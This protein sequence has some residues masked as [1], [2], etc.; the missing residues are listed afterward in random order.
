MPH[1]DLCGRLTPCK[2]S[3]LVGVRTTRRLRQPRTHV[4]SRRQQSADSAREE[5][6]R[7]AAA[8]RACLARCVRSCVHAASRARAYSS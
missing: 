1:R 2:W 7:R 8:R 5:E 6:A 4:S 3:I